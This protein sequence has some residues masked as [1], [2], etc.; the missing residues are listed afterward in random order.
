MLTPGG[1]ASANSLAVYSRPIRRAIGANFLTFRGAARR[2]SID[3]DIRQAHALARH[4]G[5]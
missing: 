5:P 3:V 4:L 2:H 1:H